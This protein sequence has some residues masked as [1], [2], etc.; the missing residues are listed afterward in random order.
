MTYIIP[1]QQ[2][3]AIRKRKEKKNRERSLIKHAEEKCHLDPTHHPL[4]QPSLSSIARDAV[5]FAF[6]E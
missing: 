6:N 5:P 1:T 3:E 2:A 4:T